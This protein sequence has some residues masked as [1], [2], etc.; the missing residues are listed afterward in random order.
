[1]GGV[2]SRSSADGTQDGQGR[3][4]TELVT[5]DSGAESMDDRDLGEG[6]RSGSGNHAKSTWTEG[7]VHCITYVMPLPMDRKVARDRN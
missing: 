7:D 1:M 2:A 3:R 5:E 6:G 4:R